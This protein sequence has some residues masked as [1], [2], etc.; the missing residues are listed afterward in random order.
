MPAGR[1]EGVQFALNGGAILDRRQREASDAAGNFSIPVV[2]TPTG[3][4]SVLLC[5]YTDDARTTTLA[6]ASL[7]LEI[8]PAPSTQPP[9]STQPAP[10]TQPGPATQPSS[11]R[12]SPAVEAHRAIRACRALLDPPNSRGCIRRAI[13][14][15]NARCRRLRSRRSRSACLRAVRRVGRSS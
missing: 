2:V 15:A 12:A 14:Q 7:M 10:A 8:Q 13:R 6:G 3:P 9:P 1:L 5:A 11:R 4:G